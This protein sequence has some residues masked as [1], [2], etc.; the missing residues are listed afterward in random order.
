MQG[1]TVVIIVLMSVSIPIIALVLG[2]NNQARLKLREKEL[3]LGAGRSAQQLADQAAR[4]EWLE[5][6]MRVVERIVTDKGL[7][8]ADEIERLRAPGT[9][10]IRD[11]RID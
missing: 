6:R 3:E 1:F 2:M 4:L 11:E 5:D 10:A 8:L 7:S 9:P